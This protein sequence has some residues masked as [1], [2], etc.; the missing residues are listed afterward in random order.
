MY[1]R[2]MGKILIAQ[3]PIILSL[4]YSPARQQ[5]EFFCLSTAIIATPHLFL[6]D[7]LWIWSDENYIWSLCLSHT[8]SLA[9]TCFY[10]SQIIKRDH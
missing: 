9:S 6:I 1:L 7:Q 4:T 2:W 3:Q 8:N 10:F 5:G